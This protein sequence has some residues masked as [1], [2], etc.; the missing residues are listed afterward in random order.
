MP[1]LSNWTSAKTEKNKTEEL[2]V[3]EGSGT[4][5]GIFVNLPAF[6][7][8]F[9][10][11]P[12]VL[13]PRRL[14]PAANWK[15]HVGNRDEKKKCTK[16]SHVGLGALEATCD[17]FRGCWLQWQNFFKSSCPVSYLCMSVQT[18]ILLLLA[19]KQNYSN[20]SSPWF[21]NVEFHYGLKEHPVL[22]VVPR[23]SVFPGFCVREDDG[24]LRLT[25]FCFQ[26]E[27][28]EKLW[29]YSLGN[30]L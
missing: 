15:R 9:W 13:P 12:P 19:F 6:P 28:M 18:K 16:E 1:Q 14:P 25:C 11:F 7:I 26:E 8:S 4:C 20:R 23:N 5:M 2:R 29:F 21:L 27:G 24:I 10:F 3:W 22:Q 17:H 30:K